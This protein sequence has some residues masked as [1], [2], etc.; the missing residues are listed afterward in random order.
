ML[1]Y[2]REDLRPSLDLIFSKK[3]MFPY[4]YFPNILQG[5]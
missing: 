4:P 2:I 3:E 1:Y 5:N